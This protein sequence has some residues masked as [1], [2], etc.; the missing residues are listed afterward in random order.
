MSIQ[1]EV[2]AFVS[3]HQLETTLELRILDL[4]SE[5]GE[6]SKEVL[7]ATEYGAKPVELQEAFADEFGD[8]AFSLFCI[9]N[10]SNID[11]TLAIQQAMQKYER[12][13]EASGLA[14]SED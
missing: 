12:R 3:K 4:M 7:K 1:E 10:Q 11:V 13:L 9:A 14:S 5:L 8:V 2:K 6:L